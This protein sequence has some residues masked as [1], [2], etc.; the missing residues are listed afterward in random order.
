MNDTNWEQVE[1][2]DT[3]ANIVARLPKRDN[4]FAGKMLK[5]FDSYGK[6]TDKQFAVVKDILARN[7]SLS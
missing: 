3:L 5:A 7:V 1:V 6:L 2:I 4:I